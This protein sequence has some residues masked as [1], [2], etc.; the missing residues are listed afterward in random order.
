MLELGT[1]PSPSE[2]YMLMLKAVCG[3][4]PNATAAVFIVLKSKEWR[5]FCSGPGQA[6][7]HPETRERSGL[8]MKAEDTKD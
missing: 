1:P 6:A 3:H 4:A 2:V 8:V 5:E 7:A